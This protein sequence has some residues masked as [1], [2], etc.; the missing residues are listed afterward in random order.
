MQSPANA[1]ALA[2][3]H[4]TLPGHGS[5]LANLDS[6]DCPQTSAL[7]K[8]TRLLSGNCVELEYCSCDSAQE[9]LFQLIPQ[10]HKCL[11]DGLRG[12][13]HLDGVAHAQAEPSGAFNKRDVSRRLYRLNPAS[14]QPEY[15]G[16]WVDGHLQKRRPVQ[17]LFTELATILVQ[18]QEPFTALLS[19]IDLDGRGLVR[20]FVLLPSV[21][22]LPKPP[23]TGL[24]AVVL[25]GP[26]LPDARVDFP[27]SSATSMH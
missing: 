27:W 6:A 19:R 5:A 23:L 21:P 13:V 17:E 26:S 10:E 24:N 15:A 16:D 25:S 22:V 2:E 3:L 8:G 18:R 20:R 11:V 7:P 12:S 1:T 14:L 9:C 4:S